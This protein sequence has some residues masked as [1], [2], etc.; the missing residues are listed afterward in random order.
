MH[1]SKVL[2]AWLR[3]QD[4]DCVQV[5][6]SYG[7]LSCLS[8]SGQFV[9]DANCCLEQQESYCFLALAQDYIVK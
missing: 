8:M 7:I 6:Q 1:C 4:V 9:P 3:E 2:G 5:C